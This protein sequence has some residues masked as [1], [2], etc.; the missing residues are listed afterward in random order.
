MMRHIDHCFHYLMTMQSMPLSSLAQAVLLTTLLLSAAPL[1]AGEL[2]TAIGLEQEREP[3]GLY[4]YK[5]SVAV[6]PESDLSLGSFCMYLASGAVLDAI[7]GPPGF[8]ID[9]DTRWPP[10]ESLC[11]VAIFEFALIRPGETASFEFLTPLGFAEE[12]D[13]ALV[14]TRDFTFSDVQGIEGRI[15]TPFSSYRPGDANGDGEVDL[16]DFGTLKGE[17]GTS[18]DWAQGDFDRDGQV[19]LADFGLLKANFGAT[20]GAVAVPEPTG[21]GLLGSGLACLAAAA[22]AGA[23][24]PQRRGATRKGPSPPQ[25]FRV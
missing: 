24:S 10:Y 14:G 9:Y 19:A 13:Y 25:P 12:E 3:S 21:L 15:P 18:G 8:E 1:R 5:Y 2:I 11:W 20:G 6:A 4:R 7:T 23:R 22:A 16:A 17:F